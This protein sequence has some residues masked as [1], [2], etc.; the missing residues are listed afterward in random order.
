MAWK[1]KVQVKVQLIKCGGC[2]KSYNNPL[3]HVCVI[4]VDRRRVAAKKKA[5]AK[6]A[7]KKGKK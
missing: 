5:V 2:G 7:K 4:R 3:K 6:N 1:P